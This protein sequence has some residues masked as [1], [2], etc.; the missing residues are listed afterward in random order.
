MKLLIASLSLIFCCLN[1]LISTPCDLSQ[2]CINKEFLYEFCN[3]GVKVYKCSSN[4]YKTIVGLNTLIPLK[5]DPSCINYVPNSYNLILPSTKT[6]H[7]EAESTMVWTYHDKGKTYIND[8]DIDDPHNGDIYYGQLGDEIIY[9]SEDLNSDIW[10]YN[11]GDYI[12]EKYYTYDAVETK[13]AWDET[14]QIPGNDIIRNSAGEIVFDYNQLQIDFD[15]AKSAWSDLCPGP[16]N[17]IYLQCCPVTVYWSTLETDFTGTKYHPEDTYA[18][19]RNRTSGNSNCSYNCSDMWIKINQSIALTG[20]PDLNSAAY[21]NNYFI[22][23]DKTNRKDGLPW[24]SFISTIKHELGHLFGFGDQDGSY[25]C[26]KEGSIMNNGDKGDDGI[27]KGYDFDSPAHNLTDDDICMYKKL[28]CCT[29]YPF[30]EV[31]NLIIT[32]V[33][34]KIF[35]NP[36]NSNILNLQ[37][38]NPAENLMNFEI[39]SP[40]GIKLLSGEIQPSENTKTFNLDGFASG[41]YVIVLNYNGK[42]EIKKF[43]INK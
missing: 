26:D 35:P 27:K 25:T 28:Y 10:S 38:N 11:Y 17:K 41:V 29:D 34:I 3:N 13:K 30:T 20:A 22:T 42:Q 39:I 14:I 31:N 18:A 23:G 2:D 15:A 19:T 6:I 8:D 16:T 36:T 4:P 21:T 12:F 7:H 9:S 24:R 32:S 5:M 1:F 33:E 37:I 40:L 43:V